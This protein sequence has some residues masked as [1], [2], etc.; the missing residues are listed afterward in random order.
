[1]NNKEW[2][3]VGSIKSKGPLLIDLNKKRAYVPYYLS[4][5]EFMRDPKK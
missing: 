1:M 3:V 2:T 4:G 5:T